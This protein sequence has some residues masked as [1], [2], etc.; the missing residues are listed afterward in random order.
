MIHQLLLS[1]T[2]RH[3]GLTSN[4]INNKIPFLHR[5]NLLGRTEAIKGGTFS[6]CEPQVARVLSSRPD[7]HQPWL[8]GREMLVFYFSQLWQIGDLGWFLTFHNPPLASERG[9][10]SYP[11]DHARHVCRKRA[12]WRPKIVTTTHLICVHERSVRARYLFLPY[13]TPPRPRHVLSLHDGG[14]KDAKR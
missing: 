1:Q 2:F 10:T 14:K 6:W 13:W 9:R 7:S 8:C 4:H 12:H 3:F 11:K 5:T